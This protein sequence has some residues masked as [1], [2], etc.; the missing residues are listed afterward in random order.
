MTREELRRT[1]LEELHRLAP[2]VDMASIPAKTR[3][4]EELD[5]DSF[6]FARLV[7]TLDQR[8]GIAVPEADY[9]RLETLEGCLAYLEAQL[10]A[11]SPK[12]LA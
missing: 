9:G 1:V 12:P 3:L 2:E 7:T 5:L 11:A 4:R 8:L 6:D 10:G